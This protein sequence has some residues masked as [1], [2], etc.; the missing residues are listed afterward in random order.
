[1][2][3]APA[4]SDDVISIRAVSSKPEKKAFIELAYRLNLPDPNW[5]PEL[6]A[7]V[8]GLI[9]PGKNPWF[10]HAEAE[11][12]LA[13]RPGRTEPVGRISAQVDS[14]VQEQQRK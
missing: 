5:V 13:W 2:S 9:T 12:F 8:N 7:E 6:K 3:S 1:M 14:L 11:Y 4:P 10:E